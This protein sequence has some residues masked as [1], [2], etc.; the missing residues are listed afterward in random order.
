MN[1]PENMRPDDSCLWD[2]QRYAEEHPES[3]AAYWRKREQDKR[4]ERA[5][6]A[7]W[8]QKYKQENP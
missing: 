3:F 2:D 1:D 5:F 6:W 4:D 8:E 7:A